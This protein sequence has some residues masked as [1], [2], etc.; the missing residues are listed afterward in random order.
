MY[1]I[2]GVIADRGRNEV[3][4]SKYREKCSFSGDS[5]YYCRKSVEV[6]LF[7]EIIHQPVLRE[8]DQ[9]GKAP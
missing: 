2:E 4:V 9:G 5:C 8:N 1:G 3:M 6:R 7:I